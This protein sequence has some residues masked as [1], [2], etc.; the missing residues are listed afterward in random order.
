MGSW[1]RNLLGLRKAEKKTAPSSPSDLQQRADEIAHEAGFSD[2]QE[3]FRRL[4]AGEL[5]GT[6]LEVELKMLRFLQ[7]PKS[8][9]P[10]HEEVSTT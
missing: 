7:D 2:A 6:L 10:E 4:D 5:D 8:R 9:Q 3:A 1:L